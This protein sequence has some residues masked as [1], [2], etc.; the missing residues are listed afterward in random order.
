M[1]IN[2]RQAYDFSLTIIIKTNRMQ[3]G[4][5]RLKLKAPLFKCYGSPTKSLRLV[6]G[7]ICPLFT[8]LY[9]EWISFC[10]SLMRPKSALLS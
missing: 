3:S 10:R 9:T 6:P 5:A 4:K 7:L 2:F 8:C 1:V